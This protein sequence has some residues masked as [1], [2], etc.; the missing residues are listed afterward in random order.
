MQNPRSS[1]PPSQPPPP[2]PPPSL[3]LPSLP[4]PSLPP[5][6][7]FS[8][9]VESLDSL[10]SLAVGVVLVFGAVLVFGIGVVVRHM[11]AQEK[12]WMEPATDDYVAIQPTHDPTAKPD[13][14]Y[15]GWDLT[16]GNLCTMLANSLGGK[17]PAQQAHADASMQLHSLIERAT[18]LQ[19]RGADANRRGDPHEACRLFE[20]AA[21]MVPHNPV[22][23]L[24]AA[25]MHLKI[26]LA[27]GRS[28]LPS[29]HAA[30]ELYDRAGALRLSQ[31][32]LNLLEQKRDVA[33]MAIAH[34]AE[35]AETAAEMDARRQAA[36][37]NTMTQLSLSP[38]KKGRAARDGDDRNAK[39]TAEQQQALLDV[40][41]DALPANRE[42]LRAHVRL[43]L[44]NFHPDKQADRPEALQLDP[45]V[46]T[47]FIRRIKLAAARL[48]EAIDDE[49]EESY[50]VG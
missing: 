49:S 30:V 8:E 46:A 12:K 27:G 23:V 10:D 38:L 35:N 22:H 3:P 37:R 25:N 24:S 9:F 21:D 20:R 11:M 16:H 45:T 5:L 36:A 41:L 28:R 40:G 43:L 44:R 7:W 2:L 17:V 15:F 1:T 31:A 18:V 19:N 48:L 6:S 33:A 13:S 26:G 47:A 50:H 14:K 4:L 34:A 39:L 29:L 42:I 32:Q